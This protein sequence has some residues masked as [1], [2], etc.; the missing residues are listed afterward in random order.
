MEA[1]WCSIGAAGALLVKLLW[2]KIRS[3]A[4]KP[5]ADRL[6][7][8]QR[9][10]HAPIFEEASAGYFPSSYEAQASASVTLENERGFVTLRNGRNIF[11]QFWWPAHEVKAALIFFHG[12]GDHCDFQVA[13]RAKALCSLGRFAAASFDMPNHG[14]SDGDLVDITDWF[15]FCDECREVVEEHLKPKFLKRYS[16]LRFFIIGESMGGGVLFT[17]L[18]REK[19]LFDGAILLAPMIFVSRD[20]FPP[21]IVVQIFKH[22]MV[23]L[24]P[25]W[26]IAPNKDIGELCNSDP[27]VAKCFNNAPLHAK[28]IYPTQPR[29]GTGYQLAFVA[30]EWMKDKL[31]EYDVPSLIIHGKADSV[32]DPNVSKELFE[33]MQQP[34]KELLMPDGVKHADV[35]HGGPKMYEDCKGRFQAIAAWIDKRS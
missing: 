20:L 34:D 29:L 30:G 24:L 16:G 35:L 11:S 22:V 4:F 31:P 18:A 1:A 21:W 10:Q 9:R 27:E 12:I 2:A 17:I 26:P 6:T 19:E 15:S 7:G 3:R 23:P 28:L 25:T 8:E 13:L 33:R 32:T 5:L 14:R